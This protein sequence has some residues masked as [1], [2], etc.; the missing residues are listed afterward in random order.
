PL[1]LRKVQAGRHRLRITAEGRKPVERDVEIPRGQVLPVRAN[2]VVVPPRGAAYTQAIIGGVLLGAG[3]YVGLESNRL[4]DELKTEHQRGSLASDD[5]RA[6]RG[7]VYSISADVAFLGATA[8]SGLSVYN[9]LRDPL[10]PSRLVLRPV[11]EFDAVPAKAA[12]RV[13]SAIWQFRRP[14]AYADVN[15]P[16]EEQP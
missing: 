5:S 6:L 14:T 4:H 3:I 10:P 8:L 7:K 9:F 13:S 11:V 12:P 15:E 2:L 16:A 1:E